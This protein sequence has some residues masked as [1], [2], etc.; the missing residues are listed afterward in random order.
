MR[1][2]PDNHQLVMYLTSTACI[3]YIRTTIHPGKKEETTEGRQFAIWLPLKPVC[4]HPG[5]ISSGFFI[6]Q[7][8]RQAIGRYSARQLPADN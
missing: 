4:P 8:E 5:Y 3:G 1:K 6:V 7:T 2:A